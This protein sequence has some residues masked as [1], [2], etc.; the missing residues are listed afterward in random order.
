VAHERPI[1]PLQRLRGAE[2]DRA[3]AGIGIRF[4]VTPASHPAI[5]DVLF[6]ASQQAMEHE[7]FRV[8]SV[9]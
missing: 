3:M 7:D 4:A 6:F 8:L 9:L 1:A 2:L 5:E